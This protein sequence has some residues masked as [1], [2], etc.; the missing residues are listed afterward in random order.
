M[1]PYRSRRSRHKKRTY[2]IF[3]A[4]A[5]AVVAFLGLLF[6]VV[7]MQPRAS[8]VSA[9]ATAKQADVWLGVFPL[10]PTAMTPTLD[11]EA[12]E[13]FRQ[14]MDEYRK[15]N[16]VH[17]SLLLRQATETSPGSA[18]LRLYLGNSL[19]LSGDIRD[20]IKELKVANQL[21][22]GDVRDLALLLLAKAQMERDD[23]GTARE[24]LIQVVEAGGRWSSKAQSLLDEFAGL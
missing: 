13:L 18:E 22:K 20:A 2:L 15:K 19:M 11:Q 6:V 8:T 10:T 16:H 21:G 5:V 4:I 17:A 3:A 9:S 23:R 7:R 12:E 1:Q 24:N 14:A